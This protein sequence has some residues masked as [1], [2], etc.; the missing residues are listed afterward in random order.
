MAQDEVLMV[1]PDGSAGDTAQPVTLPV[2][3]GVIEKGNPTLGVNEVGVN[4]TEGGFEFTEM[5]SD[6][7]V[8]PSVFVALIV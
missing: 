2:R 3:L 4:D 5:F 8:L 7:E 6:T 1:T